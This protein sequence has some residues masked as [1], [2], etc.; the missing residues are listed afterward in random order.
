MSVDPYTQL[1]V[2]RGADD[3]AVKAAWRLVAKE[4]HPDRCGDDA[5]K[6]ERFKA[7]KGAYELLSDPTRRKFFDAFGQDAHSIGLREEAQIRSALRARQGGMTRRAKIPREG[8]PACE[9]TGWRENKRACTLCDPNMRPES[10]QGGPEWDPTRVSVTSS[11]SRRFRLKP[12]KSK[13]K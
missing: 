10:A 3:D 6:L 7:C 13:K 5:A 1:G 9:G 8:C 2:A 12:A 4:C 11:G